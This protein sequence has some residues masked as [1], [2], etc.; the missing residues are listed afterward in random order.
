MGLC[1]STFKAFFYDVS[2][3]NL[4][5]VYPFNLLPNPQDFTGLIGARGINDAGEIVGAGITKTHGP[6][7]HHAF[8]MT[9]M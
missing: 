3:P 6:D 5:P 7:I 1:I 9:P 4:D 2:T 8:L